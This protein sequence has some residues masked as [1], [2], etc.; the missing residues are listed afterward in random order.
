[1]GWFENE[2]GSHSNTK[3]SILRSWSSD[4]LGSSH[5][6]FIQIFRWTFLQD[7]PGTRAV[8]AH[9][10]N[11]P[12]FRA[13]AW[14]HQGEYPTGKPHKNPTQWVTYGIFMGKSMNIIELTG[15][16][17]NENHRTKF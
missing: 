5:G 7:G 15:G 11:F 10:H 16:L 17:I 1:M 2:V 8:K 6:M 3:V 14:C 13:Q 4:D 12:L 9:G